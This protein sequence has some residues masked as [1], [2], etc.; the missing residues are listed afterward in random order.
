M[1]ICV[2]QGQIQKYK[3]HAY[4]TLK[5]ASVQTIMPKHPTKQFKKIQPASGPVYFYDFGVESTLLGQFVRID[6]SKLRFFGGQVNVF[7]LIVFGS[8]ASLD[9]SVKRTRH[10]F[11]QSTPHRDKNARRQRYLK[12]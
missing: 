9:F 6:L 1:L 8:C 5:I 4:R 7:E 2:E 12:V 3:T 11:I 10:K